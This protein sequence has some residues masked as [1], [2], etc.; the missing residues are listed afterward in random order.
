MQPGVHPG[1]QQGTLPEI[2]P[3]VC[4]AACWVVSKHRAVVKFGPV[5]LWTGYRFFSASMG[6]SILRP[7]QSTPPTS[8]S[9]TPKSIT[10]T[11]QCTSH[12]PQSTR[13]FW[14]WTVAKVEPEV[15]VASHMRPITARVD[16]TRGLCWV[17]QGCR[18]V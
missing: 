17:T 1:A 11:P 13:A 4:L 9:T 8:Q 6:N 16:S 5:T 14:M 18:A 15:R 2:A 3:G 7:P 12:T 10:P